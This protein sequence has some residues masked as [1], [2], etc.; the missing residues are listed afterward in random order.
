MK[1]NKDVEIF[2]DNIENPRGFVLKHVN[3]AIPY[4][5][6][7][8]IL[9]KILKTFPFPDSVGFCGLPEELASK[10]R[11][12]LTDYQLEWDENCYLYYLPEENKGKLPLETPLPSLK[13]ADVDLVNHYY[14]YKEEGSREYLLDCIVNRPSSVIHNEKGEPVSWALV[15]EDNSMGVMFTVEEYRKKGLAKKIT[16]DL[17][18]K[19]VD[20]GSIPY[21]HIVDTNTTSQNLAKEMGFVH[22]GKIQWFGLTKKNS[23]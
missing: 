19:V 18:K 1:H 17:I 3:W 9:N 7:E 12:T 8:G 6:D 23:D 15:R 20:Q 21:V 2:V 11:E 16:M 5:K 22:W 14:T 10:V 13:P 4:S